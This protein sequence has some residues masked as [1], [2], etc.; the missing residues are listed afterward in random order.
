MPILL[1]RTMH[2][3]I[4]G[5][6]LVCTACTPVALPTDAVTQVSG[7]V[8]DSLH[9]GPLADVHVTLEPVRNASVDY[10]TRTDAAGRFTIVSVPAGDTLQPTMHQ[11]LSSSE[12]IPHM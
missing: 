8:V 2:I 6:I 3:K 11:S 7:T 10:E 5:A 12:D 1:E 4:I 9:G